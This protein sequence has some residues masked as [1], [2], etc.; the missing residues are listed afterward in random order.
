M[1]SRLKKIIATGLLGAL[2]ALALAACGGADPT[3]TPTATPKPADGGDPA[4]T[5]TPSFDAAAYFKGKTI[6]LTV[7]FGQGGGTDATARY[8]AANWGKFIP[9]NPRLIVSNIVPVV[10]ERN[11][12][13][14]AKPDGLTLGVEATPGINDEYEGAAEFTMDQVTG[15]GS[16]SGGDQFWVVRG[17]LGLGC[18][19]TAM[20]GAGPELIVA[21]GIASARDMGSTS[22]LTAMIADM[23]DVNYRAIHVAG[24]TGSNAQMLML[25]RGD[26]NSWTSATVWNQIPLRRPGW[27]SDKFIIPFVDMSFSGT[28]VSPNAEGEFNCKVAQE[29]MTNQDDIDTYTGFNDVRASFAKNIIGPP[30]MDEGV[31]DALR[32]ALSDAM[33]DAEFAEGMQTF[34]G[35]LNNFTPGVEFQAALE[36][37]S[38]FFRAN[39]AKYDELRDKYYDKYVK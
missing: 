31:R 25:E 23:L 13:W 15:I 28:T 9:G 19:D 32:K 10:T 34:S 26:V 11:F 4:A 39:Q 37:M 35:I 27:V 24:D 3:A 2:L 38:T 5:P 14:N 21:D 6:R 17:N 1:T 8:L 29:Y 22:F 20:N 16:T 30:G 36:R 12:V 33:A 18:I 7:G